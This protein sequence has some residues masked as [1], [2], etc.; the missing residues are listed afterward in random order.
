MWNIVRGN[1]VPAELIVAQ[2][3]GHGIKQTSVI[4][5]TNA[6]KVHFL[7]RFL[8]QNPHFVYKN[9]L[10]WR[11]SIQANNLRPLWREF[12]AEGWSKIHPWERWAPKQRT[13]CKAGQQIG[14]SLICW[15][16]KPI[17]RAYSTTELK[18]RSDHMFKAEHFH[19][20][21][22]DKADAALSNIF[23]SGLSPVRNG[24]NIMVTYSER[25]VILISFQ[26]QDSAISNSRI[27]RK[28]ISFR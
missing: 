5:F 3:E 15:E 19:R 26:R 7:E 28:S 20:E 12:L 11:K 16:F 25:C 13:T 2:M 9:A 6:A 23:S 1:G 10:P 4:E 17:S 8:I 18:R 22:R 14:N 21:A 27:E 24:A